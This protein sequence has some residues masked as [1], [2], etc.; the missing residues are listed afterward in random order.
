MKKNRK[1]SVAL[2]V[3]VL[4]VWVSLYIHDDVWG[5]LVRTGGETP[6]VWFLVVCLWVFVGHP[7]IFLVSVLAIIYAV[8]RWENEPADYWTQ[9]RY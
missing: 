6:I 2:A 1:L 7:L 8:I 5:H 9:R 3:M 4:T